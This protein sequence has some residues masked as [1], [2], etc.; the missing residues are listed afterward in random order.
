MKFRRIPFLFLLLFSLT[1][2]AQTTS[3][4]LVTENSPPPEHD[5]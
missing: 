5:Q 2:N 1:G 4:H 3:F